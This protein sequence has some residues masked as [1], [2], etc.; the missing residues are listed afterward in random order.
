MKRLAALTTALLIGLAAPS[1]SDTIWVEVG[2]AGDLPATAQTV[3]F[4]S[5]DDVVSSDLGNLASPDPSDSAFDVDLYQIFIFDP[6][7]FSA[8]TVNS[9]GLYVSDPQLFLF[10]S[11]GHGVYMNDDDESALNGS[12]SSLPADHFFS[13]GSIGWYYLAIGWWDNEPLDA[14]ASL[15]FDNSNPFGTNGPSAGSGPLASWNQVV[16][17]RIDLET[18]YEIQ[19]T[20]VA[21]TAVPEPGTLVLLA[22]GLLGVVRR[23]RREVASSQ[24]SDATTPRLRGSPLS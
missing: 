5:V 10:D 13:P 6:M 11:G 20:G 22:T 9:P 16:L 1:W 18:A 4:P 17:Q 12:Q 8:S 15:V 7:G 19:L 24:L 21:S 2:D 23:C 3:E 14:L